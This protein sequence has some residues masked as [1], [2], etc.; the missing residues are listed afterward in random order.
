MTYTVKSGN[1][2]M[3]AA[4]SL[5][6]NF[7]VII[8]LVLSMISVSSIGSL[9]SAGDM[10]MLVHD[11]RIM[12]NPA[13]TF[14]GAN[15]NFIVNITN[16]GPDTVNEV[17]IY[18]GPYGNISNNFPPHTNFVCGP[19]P[20]GWLLINLH[21]SVPICQYM[22]LNPA[23]YINSGESKIFT[24][25]ATTTTE[26]NYTWAVETRDSNT[27]VGSWHIYYPPTTVDCHSPITNKSFDGAQYPD[28][29]DTVG[30]THWITAGTNILL[31]AYDP[32]PHP[33]GLH[34]TYWRVTLVDNSY[35]YD[36][37][38]SCAN[39]VGGGEQKTDFTLYTGPFQANESCHLV[40]YYS[41]DK[42]GWKEDTK[43]QCVFV[44]D[45]KPVVSV[46]TGDP[47]LTC[48][49]GEGCDYWVMDHV[50]PITLTCEDMRPHPSG[51]KSIEYRWSLDGAWPESNPGGD[52]L[53]Y[54][55]PIIFE[56]DSVHTLE[57]KCTDMVNHVSDIKTTVYRVDSVAPEI[58]KAMIGVEGTEWIG[59]CPP[60]EGS[61]DVCYVKM[62]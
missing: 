33:S 43:R 36:N 26:S 30:V 41:V 11:S 18:D 23:A 2:L 24:F 44:D 4:K 14:C 58:N 29:N 17:R 46:E 13:W 60:R 12:L 6:I 47:K 38:Q 15:N 7:N 5:A 27:G 51:V 28:D 31:S 50:T 37:Q 3:N 22:A 42:V 61:D 45:T 48:S 21:P 35:C 57:Y 52:W 16:D 59:H 49:K 39:A 19:A 20:S 8:I 10:S 9:V 56:E 40:E 25:D 55:K 53:T 32:Q 54:T 1:N 62:N 34:S